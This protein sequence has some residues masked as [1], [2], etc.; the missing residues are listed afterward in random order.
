M[1]QIMGENAFTTL[2]GWFKEAYAAEDMKL[3]PNAA[4]L[5]KNVVFNKSDAGLGN[6]YHQPVV[7]T[8]EHGITYAGSGSG[9]FAINTPIAQVL[10]DAQVQ[11]TQMLIASRIDYE[12]AARA[13]VSK[14]SFGDATELLVKN[15]MESISK[16][17]ELMF[18]Y[19]RTGIGALTSSGAVTALVVSAATWAAGIWAGLEGAKLEVVNATG[20]TSRTGGTGVTVVSVAPATRTITVTPAVGAGHAA[21]D[22]VHFFGAMVAGPTY[23]ESLGLDAIVTGTGTI[24]NIATGTYQL[25]AGNSYAVGGALTVTKI[26]DGLLPAIGKGLMDDVVLLCSNKAF[27]GLMNPTIDPVA[28]GA[29]SNSKVGVHVNQDRADKM[30]F[31]ADNI[32]IRGYQG[33]IDIIP[34]LFVKDGE[35][36]AFP[37]KML[38][39]VGASDITFN[40]PGSKGGEFFLQLP[41]NAGYELRAYL[42]QALFSPCPGRLTKYTGIT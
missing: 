31:G 42:N 27:Q 3:V 37:K 21:T 6:L 34:H 40:T 8:H 35:A 25:F 18:L 24:F 39:R 5:V 4:W 29:N 33:K 22:L 1:A 32:Q 17:L 10:Q 2:N 16:R 36:F 38:K 12:A 30:V 9:A 20:T 11:G 26:L 7:L 13:A 15:M 41:S 14:A 28:V 19:G 23:N